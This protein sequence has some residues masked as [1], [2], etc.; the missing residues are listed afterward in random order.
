MREIMRTTHSPSGIYAVR[1]RP[2]IRT[3]RRYDVRYTRPDFGNVQYLLSIRSWPAAP[4]SRV[5]SIITI[6]YRALQK[7][8]LTGACMIDYA[9]LLPRTAP[10][11]T[12]LLLKR[13]G[14]Q[15]RSTRPRADRRRHNC[16]KSLGKMAPLDRR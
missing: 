12:F 15:Q 6:R 8:C 2:V 14:Y 13:I 4:Q 16:L 3:R 9:E 11:L 5:T 7:A 1:C 10:S